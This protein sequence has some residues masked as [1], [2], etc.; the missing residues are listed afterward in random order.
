MTV[1]A[2][3]MWLFSETAL[4]ICSKAQADLPQSGSVWQMTNLFRRLICRNQK[5]KVKR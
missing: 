1:T 4:G 3:R 2:K 5:E